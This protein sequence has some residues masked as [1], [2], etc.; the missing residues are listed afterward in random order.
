MKSLS[1]G[2]F[3]S[4]IC[5]G[6]SSLCASD[7]AALP[8]E[9]VAGAGVFNVFHDDESA[10]AMSSLEYRF[11]EIKWGLRPW[12]GVSQ[13]EAGA[14]FASAGLVCTRAIN[15]RLRLSVAFAPTYYDANGG[16]DLGRALEFYSFGEAGCALDNGHVVSLR[17]GHLSNA[18]LARTNPGVETLTITY[19]LPL[20]GS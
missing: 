9:V 11:A 8:A 18:G 14:R 3:L 7:G 12:L 19:A 17:F 13:A 2:F 16:K 1:V 20:G 4:L 6:A 15:R 5:G 10:R